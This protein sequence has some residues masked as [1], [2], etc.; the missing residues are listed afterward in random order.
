MTA[1]RHRPVAPGRWPGRRRAAAVALAAPALAGPWGVL[2]PAVSAP[3]PTVLPVSVPVAPAT[4]YRATLTLR[5]PDT[6]RACVGDLTAITARRINPYADGR[7]PR[8]EHV[9]TKPFSMAGGGVLDV[10]FRVRGTGLAELVRSGRLLL[11]VRLTSTD[12]TD[13]PATSAVRVLLRLQTP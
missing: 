6:V 11:S 9:T 5:C 2:S 13:P 7:P 4:A 12:G 1:P 10:R 8:R 3:G